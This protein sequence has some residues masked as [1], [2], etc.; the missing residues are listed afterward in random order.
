M[1]ASKFELHI[2]Y[3]FHSSHSIDHLYSIRISPLL[4]QSTSV[5]SFIPN[6]SYL[7]EFGSVYGLQY[8][9]DLAVPLGL[10]EAFHHLLA[11]CLPMLERGLV[12]LG[13][14]CVCVWGGGVCARVHVCTYVCVC[15]CVC[16]CMCAF[17]YIIEIY[18]R[19]VV[20]MYVYYICNH[21]HECV[22]MLYWDFVCYNTIGSD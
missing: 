18:V 6:L 17:L 11:Y 16:V 9:W 1:H 10:E 12:L 8:Y 2:M 5:S 3:L 7:A 22:C 21:V 20:A 13:S 4:S 14:Y 15:T 19:T